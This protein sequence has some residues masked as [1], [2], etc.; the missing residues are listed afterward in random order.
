M[1]RFL[2]SVQGKC[3]EHKLMHLTIHKLMHLTITKEI[4]HDIVQQ[5]T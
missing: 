5:C 1:T 2:T 3:L 4:F